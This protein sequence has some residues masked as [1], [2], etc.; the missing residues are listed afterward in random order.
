M[1]GRTGC[2]TFILQRFSIMTLFGNSTDFY[3]Q[4]NV[5]LKLSVMAM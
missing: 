4:L 5:V 2:V 1:N 3:Y